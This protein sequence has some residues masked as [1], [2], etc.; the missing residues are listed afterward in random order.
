MEAGVRDLWNPGEAFV[1]ECPLCS[2]KVA[3]DD[4]AAQALDWGLRTARTK[5]ACSGFW[6]TVEAADSYMRWAGRRHTAVSDFVRSELGALLSDEDPGGPGGGGTEEETPGGGAE[7][8]DSLAPDDLDGGEGDEPAYEQPWDPK[9]DDTHPP[10][11]TIDRRPGLSTSRF[12]C[13]VDWFLYPAMWRRYSARYRVGGGDAPYA[14]SLGIFF[15]ASAQFLNSGWRDGLECWCECCEFRQYARVSSDR[16]TPGEITRTPGARHIEDCG[17]WENGV[18]RTTAWGDTPP[19][20]EMARKKQEFHCYGSRIRTKGATDLNKES[21]SDPC[22]YRMR[23]NVTVPYP[24]KG[25]VRATLRGNF[26]G[27]TVDICQGGTVAAKRFS[28]LLAAGGKVDP[29]TGELLKSNPGHEWELAD[30]LGGLLPRG[31]GN[32]IIGEPQPEEP[33]G[34][35]TPVEIKDPN[36]GEYH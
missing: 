9:M 21:Y 19:R 32:E 31:A 23:D 34:L 35:V 3:R 36:A 11:I 24:C 15:T 25:G 1:P 6:T 5:S 27:K 16:V 14:C 26:L 2:G 7:E 29:E 10:T 8:D 20:S 18:W 22:F 33:Y 4:P 30:V 17:W 12:R 28:F 13:C